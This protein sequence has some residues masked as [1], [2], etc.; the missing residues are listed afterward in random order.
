MV[1]LAEMLELQL[2]SFGSGFV[3]LQS[4]EP[5]TP[6]REGA[7]LGIELL[8]PNEEREPVEETEENRSTEDEQIDGENENQD[9]TN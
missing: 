9:E 8:P 5:N 2:E 7:Y 1:Q 4:V 6:L 3:V